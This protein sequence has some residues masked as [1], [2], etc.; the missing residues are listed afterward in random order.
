MSK[1]CGTKVTVDT[2]EGE[3]ALDQ[4][5]QHATMTADEVI[6]QTRKGYTTLTLLTGIMGQIIPAW[7]NMMISAVFSIAQTFIAIGKAETL[8]GIFLFKATLSFAAGALL[9]VQAINLEITK[10]SF[11]MEMNNTIALLNMYGGI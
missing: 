1:E 2:S 10:Q 6:R 5:K 8:S 3:E 11:G 9:F 4:L 7:F